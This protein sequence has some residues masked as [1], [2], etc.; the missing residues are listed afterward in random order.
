MEI[1][2]RQIELGIGV[3]ETRG[4]PQSTA[5]KWIKKIS[6]NIVAKSEKK[7]DESTRNVMED[8]LGARVVKKWFEG[9]L[10]GNVHA[11][12]IGYFFYNMYGAVSS[13]SAG[14]SAYTHTFSCGNSIIHPSLSLL[15]KDTSIS[16]EAFDTGMINTLEISVAIDDYVK[17]TASFM[18]AEATAST[19][20]PSYDTEYDFIA[21][22]ITLKFSDT[23]GGLAAADAIPAKDLTINWN[24]NLISDHIIGGYFPDDIYNSHLAIEGSFNLNYAAD[25]YKDLFTADTYKY[26]QIT[27]TGEADIGD[28][29]HPS[30]V[31]LLNRAQVMDWNRED[32]A[33][34]LV[35]EP[36]SFKA[37]YNETDSEASTVVLTNVTSEYDEP[38]SA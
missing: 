24:A 7:V 33:D 25:T 38:I 30:I 8:S 23:E 34:E 21:R 9:D 2:G 6:A 18:A 28:D 32:S 20:T 11:D 15:V 35:N 14:G 12:A 13:V 1:I 22:D 16:Q 26:I 36:I 31:I 4:T 37:F 5:E 17:F 29:D 19:D 10:E 27:I 3:E